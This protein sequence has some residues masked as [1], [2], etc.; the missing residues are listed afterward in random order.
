MSTT[1]AKTQSVY[2]VTA[3]SY[4]KGLRHDIAKFYTMIDAQ[5]HAAGVGPGWTSVLV[6]TR[7]EPVTP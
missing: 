3:T 5:I 1:P 4:P 7:T 2:Y 6:Q